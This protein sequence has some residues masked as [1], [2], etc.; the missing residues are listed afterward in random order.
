[1]YCKTMVSRHKS[2]KPENYR[3]TLI[4]EK[5]EQQ[6][7]TAIVRM[8]LVKCTKELRVLGIFYCSSVHEFY[9]YTLCTLVKVIAI[10]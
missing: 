2:S 3:L 7:F 1:M 9:A 5:N 4:Q 6:P 8:L 10:V